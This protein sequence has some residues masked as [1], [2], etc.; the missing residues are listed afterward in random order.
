M[1]INIILIILNRIF[2]CCEMKYA[3]LCIHIVEYKTLNDQDSQNYRFSSSA[4]LIS[5]DCHFASI[6]MQQMLDEHVWLPDRV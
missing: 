1:N 3:S 2:L 5:F 6:W 4:C